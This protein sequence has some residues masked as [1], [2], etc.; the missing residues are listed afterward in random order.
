MNGLTL[1]ATSM[2]GFLA[3]TATQAGASPLF[4]FPTHWPNLHES[5]NWIQKMP[6]E[7]TTGLVIA[8]VVFLLWGF[9][10]FKSLIVLNAAAAG[11]L[12]GAIIG[13]KAGAA[14]PCAV[15]GA[16]VAGTLTLTM[17]KWAVAFMG[18][19]YG[20]VVGA[21]LWRAFDLDP[22][23]IWSGAGMGLITG[24]LFTFI[25]F[26]GC[27]MMLTSLQGAVM[28]A[29]GVMSLLGK[30]NGS[31]PRLN[32]SLQVRPML[33]PMVLFI[34]TVLGMLYQQNSLKPKPPAAP[35]KK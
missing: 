12:L 3:Q 29:G 21:C 5:L 26:R 33:T 28:L 11:G 35:V 22:R 31:T 27:V 25:L 16:F 32:E 23:F 7:M 13:Q 17:L 6:A 24:G 10:L 20:A 4:K 9:Y 19:L 15:F 2:H 30:Y 34:A 18:G 14:V 8:G 1:S